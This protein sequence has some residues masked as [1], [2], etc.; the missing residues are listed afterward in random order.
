M[1]ETP[2]QFLTQEDPLKEGIATHSSILARQET[3]AQFLSWEDPLKEGIATHSS[4]L[5]R[6]IP[7][8]EEPAG[9]QSVGWQRV[10]DTTEWLST[11]QELTQGCCV[12]FSPC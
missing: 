10:G 4:I 2:A 7:W 3:P 6:R 9:L 12:C 11:T 1:Q 5:A 8:T